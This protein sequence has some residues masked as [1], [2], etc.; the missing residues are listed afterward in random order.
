MRG[1]DNNYAYVNDPVNE[2]DLSGMIGYK[3]WFKDRNDNA[4]S[5]IKKAYIGD[6][7]DAWCG[8]SKVR[9]IGC[10][11]A[12]AYTARGG[13]GGKSGKPF[14]S[15]QMKR[16]SSGEI[17]AMKKAGYDPEALKR[18]Y[19]PKNS[20]KYDIFKD[21]KQ[22]LIMKP[23]SGIGPGEPLNINMKDIR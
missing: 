9:A 14:E 18:D 23:K 20:S 8:K 16:L 11:V 17:R 19:S 12:L 6:N 10:S 5:L 2:S 15:I 7:I 22:N 3:K 4:N 1:A 21:G 13:K